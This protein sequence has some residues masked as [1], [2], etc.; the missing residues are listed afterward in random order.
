MSAVTVLERQPL[1]L[2]V[3]KKLACGD[4][5]SGAMASPDDIAE[6][7]KSAV[8]TH[9]HVPSIWAQKST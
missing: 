2:Q 7:A 1:P 4:V 9:A 8:Q 3:S 5:G 6:A